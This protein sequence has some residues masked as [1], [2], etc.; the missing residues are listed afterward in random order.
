MYTGLRE[1]ATFCSASYSKHLVRNTHSLIHTLHVYHFVMNKFQ[2]ERFRVSLTRLTR[3]DSVRIPGHRPLEAGGE[4]GLYLFLLFLMFR[5][6]PCCVVSG[7]QHRKLAAR[8]ASS[9][10]H[11]PRPSVQAV[12]P[13]SCKDA[14]KFSIC[15]RIECCVYLPC[16]CVRLSLIHI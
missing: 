6:R 1:H 7:I 4:R 10:F 14:P 9:H 12:P 5:V 8:L 11:N 15:T 2:Q 13:F 3:E 16:T